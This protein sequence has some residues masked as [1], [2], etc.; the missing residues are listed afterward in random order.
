M[1]Y[2]FTDIDMLQQRRIKCV[3]DPEELLNPGKVFP[4]PCRCAEMGRMHVH[5]GQTLFTDQRRQP[6]E[7]GFT[8]SLNNGATR[9]GVCAAI[10]LR[11]PDAFQ[12]GGHRAEALSILIGERTDLEDRCR[13]AGTS[14]CAK[15]RV[16]QRTAGSERVQPF[17]LNATE[18]ARPHDAQLHPKSDFWW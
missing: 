8:E 16:A 9:K 18:F 2:Q 1:T 15:V 17:S 14:R 7:I 5:H 11:V 3:F 6:H 12:P 4:T 10:P 13:R